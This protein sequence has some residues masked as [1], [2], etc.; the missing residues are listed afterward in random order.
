LVDTAGLRETADVVERLGIE[1][2]EDYLGRADAVLACGDDAQS[3]ARAVDVITQ[4]TEAPVLA[5]RTKIDRLESPESKVAARSEALEVSAETGVGLGELI[6]VITT[7]LGADRRPLD[8]DT[9]LLTHTRHRR[10]IKEARDELAAFREARRDGQ[11]PASVAAV[12]LRAAVHALE[13]LVGAVD[14]DDVLER[15]FASFCVG[16]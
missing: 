7:M 12:H 15:V 6:A 4:R 2:S 14:V 9:P 3:L 10:A 5:V 16:K 1:V 13:E 11:I 8:L